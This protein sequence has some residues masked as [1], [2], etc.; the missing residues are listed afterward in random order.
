MTIRHDRKVLDNLC[1][2]SQDISKRITTCE[3]R[4]RESSKVDY[5]DLTGKISITNDLGVSVISADLKQ[6]TDEYGDTAAPER[7][8]KKINGRRQRFSLPR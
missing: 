7:D 3:K 4:G 6:I 8:M 5:D 2:V 1:V